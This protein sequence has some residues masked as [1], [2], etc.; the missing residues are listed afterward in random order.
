MLLPVTFRGKDGAEAAAMLDRWT[1][2]FT[3][4][5]PAIVRETALDLAEELVH[6]AFHRLTGASHFD[7]LRHFLGASVWYPWGSSVSKDREIDEVLLNGM[8]LTLDEELQAVWVQCLVM[9]LTENGTVPLTQRTW[10]LL[11][12]STGPIIEY[13]VSDSGLQEVDVDIRIDPKSLIV[14]TGPTTAVSWVGDV[15]GHR[16]AAR[17]MVGPCGQSLSR[18]SV[19][20]GTD[21]GGEGRRRHIGSTDHPGGR[22]PPR[23]AAR[24]SPTRSG[25]C[26]ADRAGLRGHRVPATRLRHRG[27]A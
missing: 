25:E 27:T 5:V 3:R 10:K 7:A 12:K 16:T 2:W 11:L 9:A 20:R 4:R 1:P 21:R 23:R 24:G 17:P 26:P 8:I 14:P 13:T 15:C 22:H 18:R 6:V 19:P